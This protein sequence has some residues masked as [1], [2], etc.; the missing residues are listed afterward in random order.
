MR[1]IQGK[2]EMEIRGKRRRRTKKEKLQSGLISI[3]VILLML[4]FTVSLAKYPEQYATT[5][6]Y[7]LKN[8]L[9]RGD[10]EMLEYYN[11]N[12]VANG[13]YLY[14]DRFIIAK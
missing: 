12:Y 14:G 9:E 10:K 7:Q 1:T 2:R 6:R 3:F 4:N 11:R 5:L 13:K 8:D